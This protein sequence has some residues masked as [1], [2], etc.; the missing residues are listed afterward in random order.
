MVCASVKIVGP[1]RRAGNTLPALNKG[2]LYERQPM[3][4]PT[5]FDSRQNV[6]PILTRRFW[7]HVSVGDGCWMWTGTTFRR[8][9]G[10][11]W[12][13]GRS[14]SAH[15]YSYELHYGPFPQKFL[16]CHH[17]DTPGCV[18]PDHLFLGDHSANMRDC[19]KKGRTGM[20]QYPERS[21]FNGLHD[22]PT[23][24]RGERINHAKL[25][26]QDVVAIRALAKDGLRSPEI[27]RRFP[28]DESQIRR[29]VRG[30]AWVHVA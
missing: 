27:A 26:D 11:F 16:V 28:V 7:T 22:H 15:R 20:Q 29:I 13:G 12:L 25:R 1:E 5:L 19:G 21:F 6:N 8:G 24:A 4:E 23:R 2:H 14:I 30:K 10:Y 17:C 18:R 3:S 9:Y